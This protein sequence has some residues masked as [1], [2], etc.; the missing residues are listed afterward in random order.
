[1]K[2]MIGCGWM[3]V[4]NGVITLDDD[5]QSEIANLGQLAA[6]NKSLRYSKLQNHMIQMRRYRACLLYEAKQLHEIDEMSDKIFGSIK[7][8]LL[9]IELLIEQIKDMAFNDVM[10]Y[11]TKK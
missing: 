5:V 9:E 10:N 2:V 11:G 4:D 7:R 8:H 1:M 3:I 6:I